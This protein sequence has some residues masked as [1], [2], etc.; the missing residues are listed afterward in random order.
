M[1]RLF[2]LVENVALWDFLGGFANFELEMRVEMDEM[3][4]FAGLRFDAF[5]V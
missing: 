2:H 4:R 3:I 5:G 1:L